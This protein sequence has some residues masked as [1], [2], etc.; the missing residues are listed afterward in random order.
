MAFVQKKK[1][2][3]DRRENGG[4]GLQ[5]DQGAHPPAIL[6]VERNPDGTI[7]KAKLKRAETAELA[8][9]H[10]NHILKRLKEEDNE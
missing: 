2:E 9:S 10:L 7:K 4:R 3:E 8:D 5:V 1:V 6:R